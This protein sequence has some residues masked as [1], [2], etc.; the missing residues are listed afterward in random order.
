[1]MEV[2]NEFHETGQISPGCNASF[3]AL[4]PKKENP[5]LLSQFRPI[6]LVG[7]IYKTVSKVLANRLKQ[8]LNSVVSETQSAYVNGRS[9]LDGALILNEIIAWMKHTKKKAFVFKVD[10]E[11][12]FDCINWNFLDSILEQMHFPSKWRSWIRGCLVSS[13][14]SVLVNG[15]P[16]AEF[17]HFRGVRQGDPLC[18]FLFILG[19]EALHIASQQA[20]IC[21]LFKGISLPNNG[22]VVS[23]LL[24]ADDVIF[25]GDATISNAHY[26]T[27]FLRCFHLSS[28]LQINFEKSKLF[29]IGLDTPLTEE[30]AGALG[31]QIGK[32]PFTYLGIPVGANMGL[33]R[34][35]TPMIEKVKSRLNRWKALTLTQG[36][37]ATLIKS[38]LG[39]LP[40]YYLSL[41]KAPSVVIKKLEAIRRDFFWGCSN[42]DKR[43]AWIAWERILAPKECG[44]LGIG[45]FKAAN[46]ALLSR[47]GWKFKADSSALWCNVIKAIHFSP[48][49]HEAF[50]LRRTI[51]GYWKP[52]LTT[53]LKLPEEGVNFAELANG[54]AGMGNS[55]KFWQDS[56]LTIGALKDLYPAL[57]RIEKNKSC[58]V[59]ERVKSLNGVR[60]T[61]WQWNKG[62]LTLS[63]AALKDQI[64]HRI[65]LY[66]F[67]EGSDMWIWYG[68]KNKEYTTSSVRKIIE[69]CREL[70]ND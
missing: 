15:S 65:S 51:S 64:S 67:K 24:Y 35:W 1:M 49:K 27:R 20:G 32:L 57:Y 54:V 4:I 6:S 68:N 5:L 3:I 26:L 16:T 37:K 61:S 34:N 63:E 60:I 2:L 18:P 23:H 59:A 42:E 70:V 33:I 7:S 48:R 44:G 31:C 52:I 21:G 46:L 36:G 66:N 19:M 28:G 29:G 17:Q 40:L 8:V 58:T 47:W 12:A 30:I 53:I 55:I 25:L 13:R 10:F 11:K 9:I 14:S 22:P 45:G 56:W 50:P 38:I 69:G 41:F 43:I 62:T 39:S